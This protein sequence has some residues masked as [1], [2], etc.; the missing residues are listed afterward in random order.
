MIRRAVVAALGLAV[1]LVATSSARAEDVAFAIVIGNNAPPAEA[2]QLAELRYADDDAVRYY[3]LFSQFAA[4][5]RL[6]TVM[7][8]STQRRYPSLAE[9]TRPPSSANL[10]AIV[11]AFAKSMATVAARGDDPV[12]YIADSGHGARDADGNAYL[13][14]VDAALTQ[15]TLF[16]DIIDALPA[17]YVHLIIDACH[18]GGVL[19]VRGDGMFDN[20]V[21]ATVVPVSPA[22]L[23]PA[24]Q[25]SLERHPT[26]GAIVATTADQTTHEWSELESGVF[27]HEVISGLLGAADVNGDQRVE[28][29]E[30]EAFVAAAN[31]DI[32]DARAIP[33][34]IAYPPQSNRNAALVSLAS[35]SASTFLFGDATG[36]GH[37][38]VELDD[39][40]RYLDANLG[41]E[42]VARL[43]VP[44]GAR[45]Y[46]HT[47]TAEAELVAS[48]PVDLGTMELSEPRATARGSLDSALRDGLFAVPYTPAY[49]RGYVDSRGAVGVRFGE[50]RAMLEPPSTSPPSGRPT[51]LVW[52]AGISTVAS[53]ATGLLAWKAKRD[54]E[55]TTVQIEAQSAATRYSRYGWASVISG[56]VAVA[57]GA[58]AWWLWPRSAA[59]LEIDVSTDESGATTYTAGTAPSRSTRAA[60]F[61]PRSCPPA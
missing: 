13:A 49:Y 45:L 10:R 8:E 61:S 25:S 1:S 40:R 52:L 9:H 39:G 3:E 5:T 36:L 43:A 2:E 7:D 30:L 27:T 6:L 32:R 31:R 42:V 11:T 22:D 23:L 34:V 24:L 53:I 58:A 16:D 21:D 17:T 35:L 60:F 33:R 51:R 19:G 48:A 4:D 54:F 28:Y 14:L 57:S 55:S 44:T 47:D 56:V 37:F 15:R 50:P 38:Y 20:E 12:L 46:V 59:Q 29:S 18:A 26:V 41:G